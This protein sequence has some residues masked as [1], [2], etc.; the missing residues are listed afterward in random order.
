M[1]SKISRKVSGMSHA[2]VSIPEKEKCRDSNRKESDRN[3]QEFLLR[4]VI[5]FKIDALE[6]FRRST[7]AR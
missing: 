1:E 4:L 3:Q 5:G 7:S 6:I 2:Q